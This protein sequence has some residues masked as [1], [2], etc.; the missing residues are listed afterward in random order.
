MKNWF[1]FQ[2]FGVTFLLIFSIWL[3]SISV[4]AQD[5]VSTSDDISGGSSVFVFRQSRK[6]SQLKVAFRKTAAKRS[7]ANKTETRKKVRQQIQVARSTKPERVKSTPPKKPTTT[8]AKPP[9]PNQK[10]TPTQVENS[11]AFAA[12]AEEFLRRNEVDDAVELFRKSLEFDP[13][14]TNAKLGLSEALTLQADAYAESTSPESAVVIY[15]DAIS[16]NSNNSAAFAGLGEVYDTIENSAQTPEKS[17]EFKTKA[18]AAYEKALILSPYLS[19][20]YAPLGVLYVDQGEIAKAETT[21]AKAVA[22]NPDNAEVQYFLGL[23]RYKQNLNQEALAS[24]KQAIKLDPNFANAHY[25]LG[26]VY[27]R[28]DRDKD[29]VA[30]Y[31]EAV[32]IDP[33]YVEAW[34]DLGVAN[35][36]REKYDDAVAAYKEAIRIKNDYID[37][38]TNLADV[39]RQLKRFED[40][41]GE[42]RI[43]TTLVERD[44]NISNADKSEVFSKFGYCL[45]QV[46]KW[47]SAIESL[48]KAIAFK[49][50][51]IDYTNLGWAYYNAASVNL[52][53]RDQV[54]A[55][56]NLQLGKKALETATTLNPKSIGGF[57]NL[58]LT[59]VGTGDFQLAVDALKKADELKND[60]DLAK[61]ELGFAYLQLKD[62]KNASTQFK[63]VTELNKD[64]FEAFYHWGKAENALNNKDNVKDI[65]KQLRKFKS[66]KAQQMA[67]E[68]DLILRGAVLNETKNVIENKI[69]QNNPLNKIPK[70]PKLPY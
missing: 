8:A 36:N 15:N 50:D 37:A 4:F 68:L 52:R 67:Q 63:R 55:K 51:D 47:N 32:R 45:G 29:A 43:A 14:N 9:K 59:Y 57:L 44:K 34:F 3:N 38:R 30:A 21:L 22:A 7:T 17:K 23:V 61:F 64:N 58:G 53:T 2:S 19:E 54:A 49:A 26:E 62:W 60:W 5:I 6:S 56:Q 11:V 1:K 13:K 41:I 18:I 65:L 12:G 42:Y 46:K 16:N 33:K 66:P 10:P 31:K 39:Y 48:N 70:I 27:D 25:Y 35:Y 28:L 40:A 24:F 69:N 20:L